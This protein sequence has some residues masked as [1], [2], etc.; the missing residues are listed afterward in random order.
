MRTITVFNMISLDGFIADAKGDM[1]WAHKQDPEQDAFSSE[2]ASG[3]GILLFGRKTYEMMNAFWPTPAAA[4]AMPKVAEGMNA[5]PKIV[6]S[7]SLEKATWNNTTIA[8]GDVAALVKKWKSEAGPDITVL[9][10]GSVVAQLAQANAIDRLAFLVCPI[11][12]GEGL[13]MFAGLRDRLNFGLTSSRAFANG[14]VSLVYD[15]T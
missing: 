1:Q 12:L 3:D 15:K 9:G 11:V 7:R 10:S 2:N 14:N 5:R 4:Q 8:K 13:S 6:L